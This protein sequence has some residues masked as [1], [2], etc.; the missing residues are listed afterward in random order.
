MVFPSQIKH[1]YQIITDRP[2][3]E[4]ITHE[5]VHIW[6][7]EREDLQKINN[8]YFWKGD[9]YSNAISYENRP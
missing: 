8:T 9:E 2:T 7:F 6:Q 4:I 5:C 3:P 1:A